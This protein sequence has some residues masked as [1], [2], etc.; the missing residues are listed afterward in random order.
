MALISGLHLRTSRF[1]T[2]GTLERTKLHTA[3]TAFDR[4]LQEPDKIRLTC[5]WLTPVSFDMW[6]WLRPCVFARLRIP[7]SSAMS[8]F[9]SM[10]KNI[11]KCM[12][13]SKSLLKTVDGEF[14]I[15]VDA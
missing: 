4:R 7:L 11:H 5:D 15:E 10:H 12:M 6:L 3:S 8:P 14:W 1:A 9:F 13:L 2:P